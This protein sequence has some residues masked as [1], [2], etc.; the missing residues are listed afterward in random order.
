MNSAEMKAL[1]KQMRKLGITHYKE[2]EVELNIAPEVQKPKV[3][4]PTKDEAKIIKD[5]TLAMKSVMAL[6]N[7]ALLDRLFPVGIEEEA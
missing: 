5:T 3:R 6:D 2:G 7:E 4:K 1:V